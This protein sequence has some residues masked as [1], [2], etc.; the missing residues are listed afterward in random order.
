[1]VKEGLDLEAA[2]SLENWV[3]VNWNRTADRAQVLRLFSNIDSRAADASLTRLYNL[4]PESTAILLEVAE[5]KLAI[6]DY[7]TAE[8][9]YQQ[10]A[11]LE[12]YQD[13]AHV[14]I[15]RIK[16]SQEDYAQAFDWYSQV[17]IGSYYQY[18]QDQIAAILIGTDRSE[19]LVE[20]FAEQRRQ[21]PNDLELIYTTQVRHLS[22]LLENDELMT[23]LNNAL[24]RFPDSI[25]LRYSRS[26]IAERIGRMDIAE[27]DLRAILAI[28]ENNATALNALGYSLANKTDRF[29]E[30]YVLIERALAIQP[31]SPA[32]QDS[33]GWVLYKLGQYE[34]ALQYLRLAQDG[35]YDPEVIAHHAE[36][37]WKLN[38]VDEALDLLAT[39]MLRFPGNNL[40]TDIRIRILDDLENS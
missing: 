5:T 35:L 4:H 31:D 29:A 34:D 40:L 33:M 16:H 6:Q 20:F 39:A 27:T 17:N 3:L 26:L 14:Q 11:T 37:L 36:V 21:H 1:M 19:E 12:D 25:D 15:G 30:A 32:I 23:L 7:Q 10:I 24:T 18:A 9:L 38:R 28:D 13:L 2:T 22:S 8:I